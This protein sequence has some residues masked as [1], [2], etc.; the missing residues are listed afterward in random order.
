MDIKRALAIGGSDPS[1]GAG[2]EVDICSMSEIGVF[3]F[4]ALTAVT[5]QNS[6][7]VDYIDTIKPEVVLRQIESVLSDNDISSAK[8]GM[9]GSRANTEAIASYFEERGVK[10]LVVDPIVVASD[11]TELLGTTAFSILKIRLFPLTTVVTP[12]L[13]EAERLAGF[14]ISTLD[15]MKRACKAI[16]I[17]GSKWVLIKGG[18]LRGDDCV[19]ILYDGEKYHQFSSKKIDG[20]D[21][22]GTGCVFASALAACL[23]KGE[24]VPHA[25]EKAK[26]YVT[27]KI[28]HAHKLGQ[29]SLQTLPM[30]LIEKF[31]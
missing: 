6:R 17:F 3:P 31:S 7:G 20:D 30:G 8:I 18:H 9:L 10:N 24:D 19:D 5:A 1:G 27:S 13:A 15:D 16:H 23:A 26:R 22:R 28:R 25:C 14:G 4:F 12:N 11:G 29:G 2:I 21:V